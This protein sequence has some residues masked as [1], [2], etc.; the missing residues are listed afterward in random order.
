MSSRPSSDAPPDA[1][2]RRHFVRRGLALGALG[3]VGTG[4]LAASPNER[5]RPDTRLPALPQ[6][7][8]AE[9][10]VEMLQG[11]M[12][13]GRFTAE[14][15]A[16]DYLARIHAIDRTGPSVNAVI[17]VNPEALAIAAQLDAERAAG[18]LRGPLHG[19]PILI[20]DNIDTADQMRTTAGTLILASSRAAQDAGLVTRLRAA[21]MVILGKTNLSEWAN[22]RS[23]R[24]TSGWSA[25]GGLTR[26]PY[27]LDRNAC[28]SSSGTGAAISANLA[29]LGI[30][31]ETDGSIVCP[32]HAN[33][34]VGIKPTVGLVSRAGIIPISSSQDTAGPMCRSVRDAAALLSVMAGAD[35]RDAATAAS[36]GHVAAD[37]TAFCDADGLRGARIGVVRQLFNAGPAVARVMEASL[38]AMRAAG[39][40]LVD[41]V[42]IAS[43][44]QFEAAEYEVLLHE[45][46]A[47]I[48]AY[49]ASRSG[50][51]M[52]R[53]IADVMRYNEAHRAESMPY[54]G[55]EILEQAAT[56]GSLQSA[57]YRRALA[58]CRRLTR[59]GGIDQVMRAHR[60]DALV[61]PTGG[62]A[63]LTDLVN[64]DHFGGGSSSLSAVSGYPS[65]TVPAG[66]VFG[67]PVGIS[68]MARAWEEGVLVRLAYAYE[69]IT[70]AR[71][72]PRFLPTVE[73]H[74]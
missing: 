33:G 50:E 43:L 15:V 28:G 40:I 56:K 35:P 68:F 72:P 41:P 70:N 69:R 47:G 61:A 21:G 57:A 13:A 22:W 27:A 48:E 4:E 5:A 62:P 12:Q 23:T 38:A 65:V 67:L 55:Q 60:L 2:D 59:A 25:R 45:S 53:T 7:P 30:G 26:S 37:Y 24:S 10:T 66:Q 71:R 52:P 58:T 51:G 14:G 46:K 9:A 54:F 64:G 3:V 18:T 6:F 74:A 73:L 44:G 16:R 8:L 36:A 11:G 32:A 20:K 17:E 31:T 63:W 34:L 19:I 49:L 1:I 42:A 29:A 39:A